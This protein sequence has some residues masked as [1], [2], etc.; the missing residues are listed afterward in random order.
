MA[1]DAR[2]LKRGLMQR[3]EEGAVI[4]A[5]GYVFELERRGYVSAGPY[6][7][8]AVLEHPEA[9]AQ[10]HREFVRAGSDV[11]EAFT[12]YG[13]REKLRL[14]GKEDL[15]EPLNRQAMEIAVRVAA[16]AEGE[17]PLIAGNICNTNIYL[18]GDAAAAAEARKMFDEGVGW[19]ADGGADFIIAET[20]IYLD[21][22][23][24]A[25]TAIRESGLP[26]VL[27]L[28]VP[29]EHILLDGHTPE[30][31]CESLEDEGA[32]VVGLNCFRGPAT[33]MPLLRKIRERVSGHVAALPVPY[34]TTAQHPTFFQIPDPGCDCI[35]DDRPFPTALD[36]FYCNRYELAEFAREAHGLGIRYLGVCCGGAPHHVRALAEALGREPPAS[37]YSPQMSKH[38]V[39]GDNERLS[40]HYTD[41]TKRM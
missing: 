39:Y 34:R 27:T 14:V 15:L 26:A 30:A 20:F 7:P 3:L 38:F 23:R 5:E 13:H 8:L 35:P 1:E 4:C 33:M 25:L 31:A 6:V 18:P 41:F 32:D 36:P 37:A 12:Y 19:A 29:S 2:V 17:P 24:I 21:E 28:S 22:A 16:E 10:L 40:E 11:V 9:V